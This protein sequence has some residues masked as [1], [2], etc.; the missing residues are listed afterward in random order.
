MRRIK[1]S[2]LLFGLA[3]V[4]TS[5][6]GENR[7]SQANTVPEQIS[8][9]YEPLNNSNKSTPTDGRRM[10]RTDLRVV[11]VGNEASAF[12]GNDFKYSSISLSSYAI[13][14]YSIIIA[15]VYN[16]RQNG[17]INERKGD[18]DDV[19]NGEWNDYKVKGTGEIILQELVDDNKKITFTYDD[20][21]KNG[22]FDIEISEIVLSDYVP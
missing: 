5:C 16:D 1:I 14:P 2:I 19:M 18:P 9:S 12:F 17:Y 6:S 13:A 11:Q 20:G 8:N 3:F 15:G 4:I 7:R 10:P 22:Y 21:K